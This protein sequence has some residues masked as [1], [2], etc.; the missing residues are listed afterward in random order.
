[1]QLP[2]VNNERHYYSDRKQMLLIA[3]QIMNRSARAA[4]LI[5]F[6]SGM[7]LG[8]V[9][10]CIYK[11]GSFLLEDTKNGERRLVFVFHLGGKVV[12]GQW[13]REN[14]Q[15]ERTAA[16]AQLRKQEIINAIDTKSVKKKQKQNAIDQYLNRWTKMYLRLCLCCLAL[17]GCCTM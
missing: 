7:R 5:A 9:L 15:Q 4:V 17:S 11:D 2:T 16:K 6:Y 13:D 1:M 14:L 3:R 12:K 8:E 10:R